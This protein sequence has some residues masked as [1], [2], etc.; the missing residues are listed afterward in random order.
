MEEQYRKKHLLTTY[1]NLLLQILIM[2]W[3]K[4]IYITSLLV[5]LRLD[6]TCIRIRIR[7][8]VNNLIQ[9][10]VSIR[11]LE[12]NCTVP[13]VVPHGIYCNSRTVEA[14]LRTVIT[15]RTVLS[16]IN[17]CVIWKLHALAPWTCAHEFG[18]TARHWMVFFIIIRW[19]LSLSLLLLNGEQKTKQ[20]NTCTMYRG[21]KEH[22]IIFE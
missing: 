2:R 16:Q 5:I 14:N 3:N 21:I 20:S 15:V 11:I 8:V 17:Q 19:Q 1:T 18:C 12:Y 7:V 22:K 9:W 13:S 6:Y 10:Q 4:V